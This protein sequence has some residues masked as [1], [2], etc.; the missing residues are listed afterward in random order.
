MSAEDQQRIIN[1]LDILV[2]DPTTLDIK[3]LKGRPESR[4]RVGKYRVLFVEDSDNRTYII[5]VT[6]IPHPIVSQSVIT[7]IKKQTKNK[8]R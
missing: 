6:Y 7:E 2:S 4:L 1:A 8:M 3:P 5:T